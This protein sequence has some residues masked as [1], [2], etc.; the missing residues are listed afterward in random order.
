M[1][2]ELERNQ[3]YQALSET[4]QRLYASPQSG[5]RLFEIFQNFKLPE[6]Q[7]PTYVEIVGDTILGYFKLSDIPRLL[8]QRLKLS[9]DESQRITATLIDFLSPVVRR[10]EEDRKAKVSEFQSLAEKV[11]GAKT[12]IETEPIEKVEPLRTM[13][14]DMHKVHGYGAYVEQQENAKGSTEEK[15]A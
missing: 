12:P 2:K 8:Q 14:T 1:D 13:E 3:K 7:Y 10:E 5:A 15:G 6:E 11:A 9:A 4:L